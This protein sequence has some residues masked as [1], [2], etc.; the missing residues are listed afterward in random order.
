MIY[1]NTSEQWGVRCQKFFHYKYTMLKDG[2]DTIKIQIF[3][4]KLYSFLE[5]KKC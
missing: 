3:S 2:N 1:Q 4:R 5:E